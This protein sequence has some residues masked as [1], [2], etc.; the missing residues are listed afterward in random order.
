MNFLHS[1]GVVH[2]D[3]KTENLLLTGDFAL[4][5]A[6]F[7]HSKSQRDLTGGKTYT[8]KGTES[9]NAPEIAIGKGYNPIST[10]LFSCGV[11]LFIM[12]FGV[13]AFCKA[14]SSDYWYN[15]L[16]Q[17]KVDKFWST[18]IQLRH[19][20]EAE[21]ADDADDS[22]DAADAFTISE[23][24]QQLVSAL[25]ANNPAHRPTMAEVV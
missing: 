24:Y 12:A 16:I 1:H 13:P 8:T 17:D 3:L 19:K 22:S 6:D 18:H 10:D 15:L 23:E 20:A 9:Y 5:I 7:G 21:N 2:R 11:I 25:L 4:K 14:Q